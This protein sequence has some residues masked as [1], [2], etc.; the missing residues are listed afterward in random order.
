MIYNDTDMNSFKINYEMYNEKRKSTIHDAQ[1][2]GVA[3]KA[4]DKF[5]TIS[6]QFDE[7]PLFLK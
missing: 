4:D 2:G 7:T 1:G 3:A 6:T 5:I